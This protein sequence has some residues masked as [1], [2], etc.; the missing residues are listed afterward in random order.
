M[1]AVLI[2]YHLTR[3]NL[4]LI[5]HF[6][7]ELEKGKSF[8]RKMKEVWDLMKQCFMLSGKVF[9]HVVRMYQKILDGSYQRQIFQCINGI[10]RCFHL[11]KAP[12]RTVWL[13]RPEKHPNFYS[14]F[15]LN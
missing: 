10:P 7:L 1:Q 13:R 5:R 8:V 14:H 11:V 3:F 9:T 6:C 2:C 4:M 12:L 15:M